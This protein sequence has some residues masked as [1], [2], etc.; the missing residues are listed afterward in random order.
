VS[1]YAL[2]LNAPRAASFDRREL[3]RRTAP[4]WGS[5]A[6]AVAY[7]VTARICVYVADTGKSPAALWVPSGLALAALIHFGPRLWPGVF[8]GSLAA[9]FAVE[10]SVPSALMLA[11]GNALDALVGVWGIRR[12]AGNRLDFGR[13]RHVLA[14]IG[15]GVLLGPAISA[16]FGIF[17]L[18][19]NGV[20]NSLADDV[21]GW[22]A[23]AVE[24][25]LSVLIITS[26]LLLVAQA[27]P[28]TWWSGGKRFEAVLL[29][30]ALTVNGWLVLRGTHGD[31]LSDPYLVL[32]LMLW[33][34]LRLGS[35]GAIVGNLVL[36]ILAAWAVVTR[37]GPFVLDTLPASMLWMQSFATVLSLTTLLLAAALNEARAERYRQMFDGNQSVQLV[38]DATSGRVVDANPAA[39]AFYARPSSSMRHLSLDDLNASVNEVEVHCNPIQI[40]GRALLYAIV[41]DVSARRRAEAAL[42]SS[43][44]RLQLVARATNDTIWDWDMRV[45]RIWHNQGLRTIYGYIGDDEGTDLA[46]WIAHLHADDREL[47]Q[48]T[49]QAAIEQ[50]DETWSREYRFQRADGSYAH[51][52]GRGYIQFEDATPV[53]MVGVLLDLSER[54]RME[55]ELAHR[56]THDALTGLANR[57]LIESSLK[58]A[59]AAAR[60]VD[61]SVGLLIADLD[62]FKEI[63][64]SLGHHAGDRVLQ[65]VAERWR[66]ALRH[67]DILGRLA[68]DEFAVILPRAD[69][70]TAEAIAQ[71]LVHA[72]AEPISFDGH[73]RR[74]GTSI[75]LATYPADGLDVDSLVRQADQAM[76][77]A[78]RSGGGFQP[79]PEVRVLDVSN[80]SSAA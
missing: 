73:E 3:V 71:R 26:P 77:A 45:N 75:G 16:A 63:N 35:P 42:R 33:I 69:A 48:A 7:L 72:L 46:W 31:P 12:H 68:G 74:V 14:Y 49:I 47:V 55:E 67:D 29:L 28:Q 19:L 80:P 43:E 78:K 51:V 10:L 53:R 23:W 61:A 65:V 39:C 2:G 18:Q 79:A 13:T 11:L 6:L 38:L 21:S 9:N 58:E 15:Y 44:E 40:D 22:I 4:V 50:G 27:R 57:V 70:H 60:R 66:A 20:F 30:G 25:A 5:L 76:Y 36:T 1:R 64:D 56:A 34:V 37:Q 59:I 41:H 24:D 17:G 32:P 62:H 52:L 8:L 54:K